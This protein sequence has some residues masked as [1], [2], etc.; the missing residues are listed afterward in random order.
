[1]VFIALVH[2][3]ITMGYDRFPEMLIDEKSSLLDKAITEDW[4]FFYTHDINYACSKIVKDE[5]GKYKPVESI[6]VLKGASL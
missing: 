5:K 4:I 6:D 3:P 1:M 2:L